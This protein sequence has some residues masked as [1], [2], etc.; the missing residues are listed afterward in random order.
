MT[1]Q[2]LLNTAAEYFGILLADA[3][4]SISLTPEDVLEILSAHTGSLAVALGMPPEY[5]ISPHLEKALKSYTVTLVSL[6][7]N[8]SK[9][10]SESNA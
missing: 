2:E 1:E 10:Y 7:T 3:V 6:A 4:L 9:G 5:D 8:E